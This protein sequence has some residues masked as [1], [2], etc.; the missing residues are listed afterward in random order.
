MKLIGLLVS[1]AILAYTISVYLESQPTP[2]DNN[3]SRA[4]DYTDKAKQGADA[5]EKALQEQKERMDNLK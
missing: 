5:I 1:L 3:L 2:E 4:K